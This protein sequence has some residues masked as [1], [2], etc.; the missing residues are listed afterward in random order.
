MTTAQQLGLVGN[1]VRVQA[2][3]TASA[4]TFGQGNRYYTLIGQQEGYITGHTYHT[5]VANDVYSWEDVAQAGPQGEDGKDYLIMIKNNVTSSVPK[6]GNRVYNNWSMDSFSRQV[7]ENDK[8]FTVMNCTSDKKQYAVIF[9]CTGVTTTHVRYITYTS[10]SEITGADGE[11]ALLYNDMISVPGGNFVGYQYQISALFSKFNRTPQV[12]DSMTAI[13]YNE[14]DKIVYIGTAEVTSLQGSYVNYVKINF[15]TS[16]TGTTVYNNLSDIPIINQ[17]LSASGFTPVENSY[18]RHTGTTTAS[19]TK[20]VIYFWNGTGYAALSGSGGGTTLNKYIY[21]GRDMALV[22]KIMTES[23]VSYFDIQI[24]NT[25]CVLP[26][27]KSGL[28]Y[29]ANGTVTSADSIICVEISNGSSRIS[30]R[31]STLKN[32]NNV[33][34][35]SSDSYEM[36]GYTSIVYFNGTEITA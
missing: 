6:V 13:I 1:S 35:F 23:E 22:R 14:A 5:I 21:S 31:K 28:Y 3:P 2:L 12:G 16:I 32:T 34:S 17:D 25:P 29:T 15:A 19:F 26:V 10:V 8:G 7:F 11:D 9:N 33:L 20:G 18:Y 30:M 27:A 24:N 36:S 4:E